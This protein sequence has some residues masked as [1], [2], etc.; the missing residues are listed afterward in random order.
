MENNNPTT[1]QPQTVP[2]FGTP[3]QPVA[4]VPGI[5]PAQPTITSTV[6]PAQ[7]S[8]EGNKIVIFLILGI[9]IIL[10]IVGGLYFYL[11]TQQPKVETQISVPTQVASAP[12]TQPSVANFRDALDKELE[13]IKVDESNADFNSIDADLQKL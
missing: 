1:P 6:P 12:S 8:K 11:S 7:P 3:V 9:V 4:A 13:A 10:L 5:P 2:S